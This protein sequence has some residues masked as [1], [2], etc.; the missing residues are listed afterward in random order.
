MLDLQAVDVTPQEIFASELGRPR[1]V[2]GLLVLVQVLNIIRC[3]VTCPLE[4]E[5]GSWLL[6]HD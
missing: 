2:I 3:D 6:H 1:E 4:V 5:E